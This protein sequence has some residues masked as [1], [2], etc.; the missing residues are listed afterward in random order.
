[1]NDELKKVNGNLTNVNWTDFKEQYRPQFGSGE[2]TSGLKILINDTEKMLVYSMGDFTYN[3]SSKEWSGSF[4][5]Q[6]YHNFGLDKGDL[7]KRQPDPVIG[8]GFASWWILQH[9]WAYQP[10]RTE[11]R[12]VF[13]IKGNLNN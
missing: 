7:L 13:K 4:Y 9:K 1:M 8:I 11:L 5:F 6:T 2:Y 3:S 12:S 10:F